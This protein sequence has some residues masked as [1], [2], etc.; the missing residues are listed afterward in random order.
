MFCSTV[1]KGRCFFV[2]N[3]WL[4][5]RVQPSVFVYTSAFIHLEFSTCQNLM[6]MYHIHS[7]YIQKQIYNAYNSYV[8]LLSQPS[9]Y[10]PSPGP[11]G[12]SPTPSAPVTVGLAH[13][14][15]ELQRLR[16]APTSRRAEFVLVAEFRPDFQGVAHLEKL[17]V[18]N[19]EQMFLFFPKNPFGVGFSFN[20][21]A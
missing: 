3:I 19:H 7:Y 18:R 17:G 8:Y 12:H 5:V 20:L 14:L 21:V 1:P 4:L 10:F 2:S 9:G 11:Q 16:Q 15:K 13:L 6:K